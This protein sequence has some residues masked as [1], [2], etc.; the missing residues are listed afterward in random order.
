[1][2]HL[3]NAFEGLQERRLIAH[4]ADDHL[5]VRIEPVRARARAVDLLDHA[6]E[7]ANRM[8]F[9]EERAR[10]VAPDEAGA[11]GDEDRI[12]QRM[13]SPAVLGRYA[14]ISRSGMVRQTVLRPNLAWPFALN[15]SASSLFHKQARLSIHID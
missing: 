3:I 1:M 10:H 9:G 11:A 12:R 8:P 14:R 6:V 5:H 13:G 2:H 7:D 15:V 4:V